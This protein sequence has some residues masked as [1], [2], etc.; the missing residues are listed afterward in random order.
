MS[1]SASRT[2]VAAAL[3]FAAGC[4]APAPLQFDPDGGSPKGEKDMSAALTCHPCVTSKDCV[5]GA[6]VQYGGDDFCALDC[7]GPSQ[8]GVNE[9]CVL[10]TAFDGSEVQVCIPEGGAC[11]TTKGCGTCPSGTNCD[12]VTA[13]CV[14]TVDMGTVADAASTSCG[15][16]E[17]PSTA[18]CCKSCMQSAKKCQPNGCYG[19]WWCDTAQCK[20]VK[21]PSD[22]NSVGGGDMSVG[23]NVDFGV[24]NGDLGVPA[25]SVGPNGGTVSRLHFAVVGD[26]RPA[27]PDQTQ[28]YP[29]AIINKIYADLEATNPRP[30]FIV[31][32]GDYMFASPFGTQAEPQIQLYL[33]AAKQFTGGPIFAALGN[34][35]CTG[36]TASNCAGNQTSNFKAFMGALVTPLGKPLPYYTIDINDTNKQWTSKF[37][38]AACNDWDSTQATWLQGEL[39][40]KTTYTFVVRH[41][42]LG[43]N[44]AP[45]VSA[46]D[47]MLQQASYNILIVGHSHT[48]A[49][50]QKQVV[51]GN[52]GAPISGNTPYGYAIFDQQQDGFHVT[53]YDYA[54][55]QPLNTFVLP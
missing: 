6:C 47:A 22:C 4:T 16:F 21:P 38:V 5:G 2:L 52:G 15:T 24:S 43:T 27:N 7:T 9:K 25:G 29:V 18:S 48:F 28:S 37:V 50:S 55:A 53:Q 20:C 8:C 44:G 31:T 11:G 13:S 23:G 35:E 14:P 10:A 17:P 49:H 26:T 39:G 40:R 34:H 45:C 3:F 19:G 51:I 54:T 36:A 33:N 1:R 41:E 12:S 30:Q 46:M 42:P 32:T